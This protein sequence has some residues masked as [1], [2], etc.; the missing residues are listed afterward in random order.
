MK[1]DGKPQGFE[2]GIDNIDRAVVQ[3]DVIHGRISA[4]VWERRCGEDQSQ[5]RG[6][7]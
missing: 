4:L 3:Y 6:R 5:H 2:C 7:E 1:L